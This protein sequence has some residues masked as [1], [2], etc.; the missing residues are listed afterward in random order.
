MRGSWR[1]EEGGLLLTFSMRI[2]DYITTL[3]DC[4]FNINLGENSFLRCDFT[5]SRLHDSTHSDWRN[6][7][8]RR[9]V[10]LQSLRSSQP[11]VSCR[12]SGGAGSTR[13]LSGS[14]GR[15]GCCQ[16]ISKTNHFAASYLCITV[17]LLKIQKMRLKNRKSL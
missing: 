11:I 10:K 9:L 5:L 6:F 15:S 1:G 12:T 17:K 8:V 2:P 14:N 7:K 13:S 4:I 3:I 16:V